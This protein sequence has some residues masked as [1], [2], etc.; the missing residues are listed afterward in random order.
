MLLKRS[1]AL[2]TYNSIKGKTKSLNSRDLLNLLILFQIKKIKGFCKD[3]FS[4]S[5]IKT[6]MLKLQ[7]LL[8]KDK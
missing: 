3:L 5:L 1:I 8:S 7:V 2:K 4:I 6:N